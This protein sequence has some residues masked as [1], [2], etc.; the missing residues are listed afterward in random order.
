MTTALR[1]VPPLLDQQ[2]I[3]DQLERLAY[4][5]LNGSVEGPELP[6]L[7]AELSELDE[8]DAMQWFDELIDSIAALRQPWW[9]VIPDAVGTARDEQ[10]DATTR[11]RIEAA[12]NVLTGGSR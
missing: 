7:L 12:L 9:E 2:V 3:R 6:G 5:S 4:G 8:A 10:A 11:D 1:L